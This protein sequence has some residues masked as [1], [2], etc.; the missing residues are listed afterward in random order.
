MKDLLALAAILLTIGAFIPYIRSIL[1]GETRPH[2]F[3]WIIWGSTTVIVFIAQLTDNGGAGAWPMGISGAITLYVAFL[4]YRKKAD[5]S[6]T[7]TDWM[8]FIAAMA[9]IPF[10]YFTSNPLSAVLLLTTI[11]IFGYAPT[12]RKA[13]SN[14]YEEQSLLYVLMSLR[15]LMAIVALEHYSLTTVIFPAATLLANMITVCI[16]FVRRK[17]VY[18][19]VTAQ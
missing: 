15:N 6:I 3:S 5:N 19:A 14:P 16:L 7:Q 11:D 17:Y 1:R 13:Y 12:I 8:F 9:A 18:T 10:W 4:A 2:I